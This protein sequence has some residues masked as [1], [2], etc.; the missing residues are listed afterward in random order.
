MTKSDEDAEVEQ[1]PL[2]CCYVIV[3]DAETEWGSVIV[4]GGETEWGSDCY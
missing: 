3:M 2:S 4:M 1:S